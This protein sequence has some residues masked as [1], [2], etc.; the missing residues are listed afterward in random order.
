MGKEKRSL[1]HNAWLGNY[2]LLSEWGHSNR[3]EY[4]SL[5]TKAN[6]TYKAPLVIKG[7]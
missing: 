5:K 2:L 7:Y 4:I 3:V 1:T 6:R